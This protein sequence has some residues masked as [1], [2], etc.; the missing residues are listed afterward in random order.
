MADV[1]STGG[2]AAAGGADEGRERTGPRLKLNSGERCHG[3][4]SS[5]IRLR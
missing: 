1:A 5:H 2:F 4:T 3:P